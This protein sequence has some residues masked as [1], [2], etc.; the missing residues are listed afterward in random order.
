[1]SD[2]VFLD[3]ASATPLDETVQAAM[4]PYFGDKFYNPSAIY[5]RSKSVRQSIETARTSV[6][7]IIGAKPSEIYFTAGGSEANNQALKGLIG[8]DDELLV[9]SIEHESVL[10]PAHTLGGTTLAVD[11]N[12]RIDLTALE[13]KITDKTKMVSIMY[14]NNEIGTI[15]PIKEVVGLVERVRKDRRKRS[16][17]KP[18]YIHTDACQAA[19]YLDLHISRLG[20]DLMTLNGGKIYGPKQSGMLFVR[21]GIELR[22]LI[23]GGGQERG[24]RSGTENVPSIIGFAEALSLAQA[25]RLDESHRLTEIREYAFSQLKQELPNAI[26]NGDLKHRLANNIH[27]TLPASDNERLIFALDERGIMV[28]AGSACSAS[29][30][31][32]SHVLRA[33]GVSDKDAQ[34]SLRITMGRSTSKED[35]DRLIGALIDLIA[36]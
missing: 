21:G 1:M 7:Q 10:A 5:L 36:N 6:A 24:L 22:P 3:Y 30:E 2:L 11:S 18:I 8:H 25:K 33:I 20:V 4:K 19:N 12:G 29:D 15:Q 23:E 16:V 31:T 27:I 28:A 9:S 35:I 13:S 34:S 26:I 17:S 32:P 14:A